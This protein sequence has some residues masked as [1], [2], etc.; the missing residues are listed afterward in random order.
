MLSGYSAFLLLKVI[1]GIFFLRVNPW[2]L[3]AISRFGT[4]FLGLGWFAFVIG[5]ET[6]FRKFLDKNK[7]V[8]TLVRLIAIEVIVLIILYGLDLI[9]N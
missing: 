1:E 9:I 7:G 5:S 6:Y 4:Y 8:S 3:R 2:Q